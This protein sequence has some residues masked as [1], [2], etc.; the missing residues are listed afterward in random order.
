[1]L[2]GHLFSLNAFY[3]STNIVKFH[4]SENKIDCS[5]IKTLKSDT[6]K[7]NETVNETNA[8]KGG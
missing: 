8:L 5:I 3:S 1:M 4:K 7:K 6:T 2:C